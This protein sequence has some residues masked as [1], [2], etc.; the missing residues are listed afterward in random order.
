MNPRIPSSLT[1]LIG[2]HARLDGQICKTQ[3]QI[4]HG[5]RILAK[6]EAK[7]SNLTELENKLAELQADFA[8]IERALTMHEIRVKTE[9]IAPIPPRTKRINLPH[10]ELTSSMLTFLRKN[11][12]K[13]LSIDELTLMLAERFPHLVSD[14]ESLN[15]IRA[16]IRARMNN[17]EALGIAVRD[18]IPSSKSSSRW[19]LPKAI[20]R[21]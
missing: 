4:A 18:G 9:N 12:G 20:P 13:P 10:G 14:S 8:C 1:W 3:K 2:K 6:W 5:K 7:L 11:M 19:S 21:L 17:L 15:F 16:R